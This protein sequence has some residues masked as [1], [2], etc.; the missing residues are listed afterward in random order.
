MSGKIAPRIEMTGRTNLEDV[1]PLKAPYNLIIDPSSVCNLECVFCPTGDAYK[2]KSLNNYQGHIDLDLYKK[3]IDQIKDFN[4]EIKMLRLWKEG[5]PLCNPNLIS[6]IDYARKNKE[7]NKIDTTTNAIALS[8]EL[9]RDL[10][11]SKIDRINISV[12]GLNSRAYYKFTGKSIDFSEY[13]ENIA[14]LHKIKNKTEIFIKF[15]RNLLFG[16]KE[17]KF[18]DIF[19]KYSDRIFIEELF[20][21]WESFDSKKDLNFEIK[22]HG[23]FFQPI[24]E[25]KKVCTHMF[26]NMMVNVDGTVSPCFA[27][28]RRKLIVG[29]L[30]KQSLTEVWNSL[31]FN[32]LRYQHLNF[33]RSEN[34]ICKKCIRLTHAMLDDIDSYA[35]QLKN[36]ILE[37]KIY[38]SNKIKTP[39]VLI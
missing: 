36:L 17:E 31:E 30:K 25:N 8:R 27:D 29:D 11:S 6:M 18:F 39:G 14:Y 34:E 10:I 23:I 38:Q 12:Y 35:H 15:P 9:S 3:I 4:S 21:G 19:A 16:E 33:E 5:E 26:Y 24:Q 1:I 32:L 37:E 28:W 13:V 2:I 22:K 20:P 7:I